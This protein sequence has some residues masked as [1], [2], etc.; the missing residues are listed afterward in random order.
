MELRQVFDD[1]VRFETVLWNSVDA[2]LRV[3]VTSASAASTCCWSSTR[4][5]VP[6]AGHREC[7]RHHRGRHQPGRRPRRGRRLVRRERQ[8]QRSPLVDR[9]A[10]G[11]RSG[12]AHCWGRG[13]D[14]ELERLLLSPCRARRSP[15]SA[16]RSRRCGERRCRSRTGPSHSVAA[17]ERHPAATGRPTRPRGRRPR[18]RRRNKGIQ[19]C[20]LKSADPHRQLGTFAPQV[21]GVAGQQQRQFDRP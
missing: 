17:G 13:L 5:P 12:P 18:R 14:T 20:L 11:R 15:S 10:H 6:G 1:L 16:R 2:S 7:A 8:P 19:S 21:D 3:S 4:P 9:R